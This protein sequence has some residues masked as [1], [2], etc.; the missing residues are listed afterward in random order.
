MKSLFTVFSTQT[1]L[2]GIDRGHRGLDFHWYVY[3]RGKSVIP[4][5][6]LIRGYKKTPRGLCRVSEE[7]VNE[8]FTK[9]EAMALSK[10]LQEIHNVSC[11]I[12]LITKLPIDFGHQGLQHMVLDRYRRHYPIYKDE[13]YNLPFRVR[14]YFSTRYSLE[15]KSISQ[16]LNAVEYIKEVFDIVGIDNMD[17]LLEKKNISMEGLILMMGEKGF[18]VELNKNIMPSK[19][20]FLRKQEDGQDNLFL[21][22]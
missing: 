14:G 7:A 22:R 16:D 1:L 12:R 21:M 13:S 8:Y 2:P 19:D 5:E 20:Y 6:R 4:Y 18:Y 17:E 9:K 11:E 15:A 10:Y 3:G